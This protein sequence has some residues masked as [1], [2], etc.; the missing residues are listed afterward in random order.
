[1]QGVIFVSG[2]VMSAFHVRFRAIARG[3][4]R[5]VTPAGRDLAA[6]E[7]SRIFD[8]AYSLV[9]SMVLVPCLLAC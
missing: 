1:M 8:E 4:L 7:A 6:I 9:T 5:V 3:G 2:D